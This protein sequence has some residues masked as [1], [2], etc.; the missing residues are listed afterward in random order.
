MDQ[1]LARVKIVAAM[2]QP[3]LVHLHARHFTSAFGLGA[4]LRSWPIPLKK[5]GDRW[6]GAN[7]ALVTTSRP[8]KI[9][10][11]VFGSGA[12]S[13]QKGRS[14]QARGLFNSIGANPTSDWTSLATRAVVVPCPLATPT[15]CLTARTP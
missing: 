8:S 4:R 11:L 3:L 14:R 5:S 6:S 7:G 15:V 12:R 2:S 1:Q 10:R 9:N 13:G